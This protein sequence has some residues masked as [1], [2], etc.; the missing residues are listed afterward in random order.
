MDSQFIF[1]ISIEKF[2]AYLDDNLQE[3]EMQEI[4]AAISQNDSLEELVDMSDMIDEDVQTY[5]QDDFTYDADMSMLDESD[6]EIPQFDE[7]SEEISLV[8]SAADGSDEN[9]DGML[10]VAAAAEPIVI[11]Q[12]TDINDDQYDFTDS[13]VLSH[14]QEHL[15]NDDSIFHDENNVD[16]QDMNL[17][18]PND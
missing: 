17:F 11:D 8:A 9:I 1:P 5:L 7:I 4:E 14:D 3:N 13:D 12:L 16:L 15:P 2:A 6:F 18:S 10:D